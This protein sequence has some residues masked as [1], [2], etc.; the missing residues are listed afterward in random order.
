MSAIIKSF[1]DVD[2]RIRDTDNYVCLTDMAN[3]CGKQFGHWKALKSTESYL[4]ALSSAVGKPIAELIVSKVG[5]V[6]ELQGTWGHPKIAIRFA[7]WCSDEFAVQVDFWIEELMTKGK[8]E[9]SKPKSAIELV[10]QQLETL[11]QIVTISVEHERQ[12]LLLKE[13][14][15]QQ[16]KELALVKQENA[17]LNF[18]LETVEMEV[19]ANTAELER[20]SNGHGYW[21]SIVGYC[22]KLGIKPDLNWVTNQGRRATARCKELNIRPVKIN[23][24]RYGTVNTYPDSVLETLNWE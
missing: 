11:T 7:Q 14:T 6:P 24:P 1:N 23:D 12:L 19:A 18:N 16:D 8:V 20:F 22:T 15:E 9:L 17:T 10:Q 21:F 4:T 2:I 5:G 13:K 3:A